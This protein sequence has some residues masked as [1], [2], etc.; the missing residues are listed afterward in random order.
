MTAVLLSLKTTSEIQFQEIYKKLTLLVQNCLPDQ[1]KQAQRFG[2]KIIMRQK[3]WSIACGQKQEDTEETTGGGSCIHESQ[4]QVSHKLKDNRLQLDQLQITLLWFLCSFPK[5]YFQAFLFDN[6][7]NK[8]LQNLM[9]MVV[10]CLIF[11]C[12]SL[13]ILRQEL[14]FQICYSS[15]QKPR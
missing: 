3:I 13:P 11:Q 7:E 2:V 1:E 6:L 10:P 9:N 15:P 8:I 5:Y 4:V 12:F 14:C